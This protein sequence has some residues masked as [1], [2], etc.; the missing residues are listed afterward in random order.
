MLCTSNSKI[1]CP[2]VRTAYLFIGSKPSGLLLYGLEILFA[3]AAQGANPLVGNLLERG[4]GCDARIGISD[5]GVIDP[6]T[7]C[8]SV[9]FH[10][11]VVF[12]G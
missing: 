2:H 11:V 4:V 3:Y 12:G 8:A 10:L 5:G 6:T 9:L 1:G 7:Y